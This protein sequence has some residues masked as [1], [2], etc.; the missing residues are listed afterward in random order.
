M[1]RQRASGRNVTCLL[2]WFGSLRVAIVLLVLLAIGTAIGGILPQAPVT[3]DAEAL[4]RSYGAFWHRW[5]TRLSLD[6]VFHSGWFLGLVGLFALN[7]SLCTARR[8]RRA[9]RTVGTP[10]EYRP[11]SV[12]DPDI[13]ILP[14]AGDRSP[15][16]VQ[17]DRLLRRAGFRRIERATANDGSGRSQLVGRRRR[18][19]ALG[20]DLS[21]L[22]IL[23]I[24]VGA[25]L[26]VFR[27]EGSLVVNAWQK[28]TRLSPCADIG[29]SACPPLRLDL[30]VDDFGAETY[31]NTRRVKTYWA[32]LSFWNE[33]GLVEQ[34]R[35]EVNRP[36]TVR[37]VGVYPWRYGRDPRAAALTLHIVD[38]P[39]DLVTGQL[40][41]RVGETVALPETG[42][43]IKALRYYRTFALDET[44]EAVDLGN[45]PGGHPA[46][47]L[48]ITGVDGE[49]HA[50]AYRDVAFPFLPDT[51]RSH[52]FLLAD[53]VVP[54]YLELR[55]VR[56]PGYP[57]VW[58]GFVTVMVG[59]GASFYFKPSTLRISVEE[60]RLVIAG[61]GARARRALAKGLGADARVD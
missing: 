15:H 43:W 47:L 28:G 13:L 2:R 38:R 32:E 21:H 37:G 6:D 8:A 11:P 36:L 27:Q 40:E 46:A 20:P 59:L 44:G 31:P 50:V 5:I 24:L 7:L 14:I 22:G 60:E 55:F 9:I 19:G 25:L 23:V 56:N 57:V 16:E 53:A 10:S 33:G 4:Y 1:P 54:A 35:V 18:W 51:S 45:L 42:L 12:D 17:A 39:R 34:G 49:G 30:Q 3:P 29:D 41:L 58:W 48:Q 26:G 52:A 61:K